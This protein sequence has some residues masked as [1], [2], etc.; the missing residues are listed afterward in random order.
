M[1]KQVNCDC[2]FMIR[3]ESDDELVQHVQL[4]GKTAHDMD[5]DREQALSLAKPVEQTIV[6]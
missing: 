2:G 5:I 1:A 4:H 3:S 6:T